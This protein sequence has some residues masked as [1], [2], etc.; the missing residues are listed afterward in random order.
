MMTPYSAKESVLQ[1][2]PRLENSFRPDS[3]LRNGKSP[4][5]EAQSRSMPVS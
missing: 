5:L 4:G 1:L 3:T 2:I